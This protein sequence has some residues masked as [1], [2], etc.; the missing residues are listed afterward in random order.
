MVVMFSATLLRPNY[1]PLVVFSKRLL[2]SQCLEVGKSPVAVSGMP[3]ANYAKL[4]TFRSSWKSPAMIEVVE[5]NDVEKLSHYRLVWNSLFPATPDRFLLSNI[6]LVRYLLAAL[7][8]DQKMR[9]LVVYGGGEPL[10][11]VPF[12]VRREAYRVGRVRVLTY[13]LDNWSTWY[14]PI[15][16]NPATTML[17]AMQHLRRTP[18]DWD[19]F[20]LRWVPDEGV[21]GGKTARAMRIA[22]LFSQNQEYQVTSLVDLPATFDE[23]LAGKSHSTAAAIPAVRCEICSQRVGPNIIRHRP[24]PASEGDGDPRGICM[25][26]VRVG[27]PGQLAIAR[28]AWQYAYARAGPRVFPSRPRGRGPNRHG[29]CERA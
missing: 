21:Q 20:E 18:R 17:A 14:G 28:G 9:V 4:I 13:P 5:I 1:K 19:M 6:R 2:A 22:G 3:V 12:C 15:G 29:G 25:P 10:G 8:A 26:P 23:F 7:W 24:A 27:R 16:P 11:I